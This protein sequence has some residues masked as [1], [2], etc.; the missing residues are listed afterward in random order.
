MCVCGSTGFHAIDVFSQL[1]IFSVRLE[2]RGIA[3]YAIKCCNAA[4]KVF[5]C[6]AVDEWNCVLPNRAAFSWIEK[7]IFCVFF[8]FS[9]PFL[10][11]RFWYISLVA[12]YRN[13]TT[14]T[15]HHFDASKFH[16]HDGTKSNSKFNDFAINY[17]IHL[18]N[19]NPNQSSSNPLAFQFS[20]DQQNILEMNLI[21]F[22]VYLILVPM[23]I[24]A[25][26][27]QKHPVTK[28][29]TLS[30]ILEFVSLVFILSYYIRYAASGVGNESIKTTG[31]I[32]DI[33]SRVC[34][35]R[36]THQHTNNSHE[37]IHFSRFVFLF[38]CR[39]RSCWYCCCWPK[40][41]LSHDSRSQNRDGFYWCPFG[42][43]IVLFM[44]C[45][46]CGIELVFS[47]S[48][49]YRLTLIELDPVLFGT[50]RNVIGFFFHF[51][52]QTEVDVISDIDEYQTWPGWLVLASRSSI[53]LW[54]LWELRNTMKYEHSTRKLDF[55]LHF[56]AS[57]L[58]WFIYL[59]V[60]AIVALQVNALWRY[61]LLLGK[62]E[63][64]LSHRMPC[65]MQR[66]AMSAQRF[67]K[68]T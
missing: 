61:K 43:R 39:Q 22:F 9:A 58:V 30:L 10:F 31:D 15:W 21:F 17:D 25:V 54:F 41:G 47:N 16:A 28:L 13:T 8:S 52:F 12:C 59:P 32:L 2:V 60:V 24:Y 23:Q 18:V 66:I 48:D 5:A 44:W 35:I 20:F 3:W 29:F 56:G 45:Y 6:V 51:H 14:C 50:W 42:Y 53:M 33:L 37:F 27:I 4:C 63:H 64:K 67:H 36:T 19:G 55:L 34:V 7:L 65:S 40:D 38:I 49:W 11:H 68:L 62:Y 57:S 26:R 46:T 1:F